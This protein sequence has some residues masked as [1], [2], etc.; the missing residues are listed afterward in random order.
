M[1]PAKP[2]RLSKSQYTRG[3]QCHKSLWLY[4][5]RRDLIPAVGDGQQMIFDQGQVVGLLAHQRFPGGVLIAEDHTQSTEAVAS[6]LAANKAG[7]RAIYEAGAIHENVL[8]RADI[9][10]R[11][12]DKKAWDLIEV[13]SSTEVKD[14][15]LHD[16]AVQRYVLKGAGFPIRKC[17]LMHINNEYVRKGKIDPKAFFA[18]TDVTE[19]AIALQKTVP[20]QLRAMQAMLARPKAPSTEI[21]AQCFNPY[22]CGFTDHCWSKVPDY[23][24]FDL[25]GARFE[26]KIAWWRKGIKSVAAIPDEDLSRAQSIQ[27]KVAKSKRSHID[28]DGISEAL[29]E[30]EYPLYFLDFETVNPA[31]PPYDGLRPF[32]QLT[33]QASVHVLRRKG[34]VLGHEEFLDDGRQDPRRGMIAFLTRVIGPK[35][36][37]VAYNKGF[38]GNCLKELAQIDARRAKQ[39]LSMKERLWDLGGPFRSSN[40]VH[41]K[42][43]GSW[44]IKKVLPTLIPSM[45]YEGM[46][47]HDGGGAQ[48]AY[49]NLMSGKLSAAETQKTLKD[50]RAYCG[51]DT[52][53]MVQL[54]RHM[55]AMVAP[56]RSGSSRKQ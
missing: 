31:L 19:E 23:S 3:L 38:E 47:I 6:T 10:V 22:E 46:P 27:V 4:R 39:L 30:L 41:P 1:P 44:S 32:Q 14:V 2:A 42:F 7:A 28:L 8:V 21:G 20:T 51:Q 54:L 37:I 13:K 11:T 26:K 50:L 45:T 5:N 9:I 49:A 55:E 18:L 25:G 12:K 16:V 40:Y 15:Y 33:F 56:T 43:Q 17:F 36:T 48:V 29:D 53:A 52:M 24:V 34:G 35:G